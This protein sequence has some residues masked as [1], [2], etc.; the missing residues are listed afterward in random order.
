MG[1][2]RK[3]TSEYKVKVVLEVLREA[4][5]LG[6]IAAEH[7][8]NPNQLATWK[9]EFLA[10]APGVFEGPSAEKARQKAEQAAMAEKDRLLKTV[11]QL[12][13]ERDF[14]LAVRAK[15]EANRRFL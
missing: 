2:K 13:M 8:I 4:R 6:E 5:T 10:K 7:E 3:F 1:R 14:L 11:G 9:R 15:T 12:T